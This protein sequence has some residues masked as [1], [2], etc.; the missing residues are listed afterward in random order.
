MAITKNRK[1]EIVKNSYYLYVAFM[2]LD[3]IHENCITMKLANASFNVA[4]A[5]QTIGKTLALVVMWFCFRSL[6][7]K[8][9][10]YLRNCSLLLIIGEIAGSGVELRYTSKAK[11]LENWTADTASD[12]SVFIMFICLL[13]AMLALFITFIM[14]IR[15]FRRNHGE[16]R[17]LGKAL[18]ISFM[19]EIITAVAEEVGTTVLGTDSLGITIIKILNSVATTAAL[20]YVVYMLRRACIWLQRR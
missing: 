5:T 13:L 10:R 11:L 7:D 12:S 2:L 1:M 8:S 15:L 16:L 14:G 18:I 20:L 4:F 19:L 17:V 6:L 9:E 3:F